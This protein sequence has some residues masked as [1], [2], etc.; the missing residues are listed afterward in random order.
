[1][2]ACLCD[3]RI[4]Q[5]KMQMTVIRKFHFGSTQQIVFHQTVGF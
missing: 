5:H 1:M 3:D 2:G 4:F